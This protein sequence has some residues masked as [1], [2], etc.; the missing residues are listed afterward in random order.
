MNCGA[1][2]PPC[3]VMFRQ[4]TQSASLFRKK[5]QANVR[6]KIISGMLPPRPRPIVKVNIPSYAEVC[7]G[8]APPSASRDAPRASNSPTANAPLAPPAPP[9]ITVSVAYTHPAPPTDNTSTIGGASNVSHRSDDSRSGASGKGKR[10][11]NE[12]FGEI[13]DF[14]Y[15][16]GQLRG[17]RNYRCCDNKC[18]D[19]VAPDAE[20]LQEIMRQYWCLDQNASAEYL[21]RCLFGAHITVHPKA[22][23]NKYTISNCALPRPCSGLRCCGKFL[24]RMLNCSNSLFY[25]QVRIAKGLDPPARVVVGRQGTPRTGMIAQSTAE[26]RAWYRQFATEC[27]EQQPNANNEIHCNHVEIKWLYFNEYLP[28]MQA[29]GI[30]PCLLPRFYEAVKV[31][32]KQQ[33]V[34]RFLK[35]K[36]TSSECD[37]CVDLDRQLAEAGTDK[38][39]RDRAHQ[40][41]ALHRKTWSED[42]ANYWNT[43]EKGRK[44]DCISITIDAMAKDKTLFPFLGRG[45]SSYDGWKRHAVEMKIVAV[46]VHGYKTFLFLVP[47]WITMNDHQGGGLIATLLNHVLQQMCTDKPWLAH[48]KPMPE[49]LHVNV[50][51]GSENRNREILSFIE[52][53]CA[54]VF[55]NVYHNRL[56][57]GHTHNDCD[58]IFGVIWGHFIG[59]TGSAQMEGIKIPTHQAF[60]NEIK[61]A[62][63]KSSDTEKSAENII[64]L[65]LGASF[66][67]HAWMKDTYNMMFTHGIAPTQDYIGG[68]VEWLD[69]EPIINPE[70][71]VPQLQPVRTSKILHM[72]FFR[73]EDGKVWMR[74][75][76][77]ALD[78]QFFPAG[79]DTL[80]PIGNNDAGETMYGIRITVR[81][82]HEDAPRL[83][84]IGEWN[85]DSKRIAIV[86][87]HLRFKWITAADSQINEAWFDK[88]PRS[89]EEIADPWMK[90]IWDIA[91]LT[92]ARATLPAQSLATVPTFQA[93]LTFDVVTH[94][95]VG[96]RPKDKTKRLKKLRNAVKAATTSDEPVAS[97]ELTFDIK[98][99]DNLFFEMFENQANDLPTLPWLPFVLGRATH[100]SLLQQ[101]SDMIKVTVL[102]SLFY[103]GSY[104]EVIDDTNKPAI[105]TVRKPEVLLHMIRSART[106]HNIRLTNDGTL[107]ADVKRY[108]SQSCAEKSQYQRYICSHTAT[109]SQLHD[110]GYDEYE[111]PQQLPDTTVEFDQEFIVGNGDDERKQWFRGKVIRWMPDEGFR[112]RYNDN[113]E[114][115]LN[116]AQL[117]SFLDNPKPNA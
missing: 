35:K 87:A 100:D 54:N 104:E 20:Q 69:D 31:E 62:L 63:R 41:R 50:D 76:R 25:A 94:E 5:T 66:N 109:L 108:L 36:G 3:S 29:E 78:P 107:Y 86:S 57:P 85:A 89:L 48:G 60:M 51:G 99:G 106:V 44:M 73:R 42:R 95:V 68:L 10:T 49:D 38:Y 90:P 56:P 116:V 103:M 96:D 82:P 52:L 30:N 92:E 12:K 61:V 27:G 40:A 80:E 45:G 13:D 79:C 67:I 1:L 6:N 72:H 2:V 88:V 93:P 16:V 14:N 113:T 98:K 9:I 114:D 26:A 115:T 59:T 4:N 117:V 32:S 19:T 17:L 46:I 43:R 58:Q 15:I 97:N 91:V 65:N 84:S 37:I 112:V 105:L 47:E 71:E 74:W 70:H 39:E 77:R 22:V 18:F 83:N 34:I 55:K 101:D 110:E 24:Q 102:H 28:D 81:P 7:A 8:L 64:I 75:K 33:P 53:L 23:N 111:N 11:R 21:Q